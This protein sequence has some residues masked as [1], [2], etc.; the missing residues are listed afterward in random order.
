MP[1][2]VVTVIRRRIVLARG[3][4][5]GR[6]A[7]ALAS[8]SERHRLRWREQKD[9]VEIDFPKS[10][11]RRVAKERIVA[12]LTEIDPAWRRLFVVYPTESALR[13]WNR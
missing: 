9:G 1:R 13:D 11:G 12:E 10:L 8:L 7:R 4:R 5:R 3:D 2:N 6:Q